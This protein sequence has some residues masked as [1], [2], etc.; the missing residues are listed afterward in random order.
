MTF[1]IAVCD[2]EPA[3]LYNISHLIDGILSLRQIPY[4]LK[5]FEN[6][7]ELSDYIIHE[8]CAFD[9]ILLDILL[10]E[11]N[12]VQL[13]SYLR[14][15]GNV[16]SILFISCSSDFLLEGCS[17]EP[18]GY[19]LK[20]VDTSCLE[21]ALLRAYN[22]LRN[23]SIVIQTSVSTT[24]FKPEEFLFV[25][26]TG[27]TLYIHITT[28]TFDVPGLPLNHLVS[29]LPTDSFFQCHRSYVVYLPAIRSIYRYDIT[30]RNGEAIPVSRMRYK[31]LQEALLDWTV[32]N[33]LFF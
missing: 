16:A 33:N 20:P 9:L 10:K 21:K 23:H 12:G 27:K 3:F 29:Q 25:E 22:K 8:P 2:D 14:S 28:G 32:K 7:A 19:I 17:V 4:T 31:P 11:A 15:M 5:C 30:L 13:A 18:I 26:V 6:A 1:R 24:I